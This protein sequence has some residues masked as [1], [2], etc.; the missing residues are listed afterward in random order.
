MSTSESF[1]TKSFPDKVKNI[2]EVSHVRAQKVLEIAQGG[3]IQILL[4]LIFGYLIDKKIV[5]AYDKNESFSKTLS[6]FMLTSALIYI[7]IYYSE[8]I[9]MLVPFL[10]HYTDDYISNRDA[11][12]SFGGAIGQGIV[13][14]EVMDNYAER[15]RIVV[16][17]FNEWAGVKKKEEDDEEEETE[18]GNEKKKKKKIK[19]IN[20]VRRS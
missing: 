12:L 9:A 15:L 4:S 6:L 11:E 17:K 18:G 2:F 20:V 19:Y 16:R 10:F 7:Y 1:A 13:L 3:I 5:P 8:K 14:F